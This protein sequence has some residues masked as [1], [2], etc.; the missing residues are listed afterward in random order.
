VEEQ[1]G[2]TVTSLKEG[3][4]GVVL[5]I[6]GRQSL[7]SRLA[8]MGIM[9]GTVIK[10]LR[11]GTGPVILLASDTRLALGRLEA[12]RVFVSKI[13]PSAEK[14]ELLVALAGQPNVGKSTVFNI[15][16]G[17]SQAVGNWPGKTV[18]KKEGVHLASN[19]ELHIVDLPG[20]YGLTAFSE[21]ERAAREF[22]IHERPD[23]IVAVVNAAALERSLYLLSELLLLDIPIVVAVNMMD[24]AESQGIR[25]DVDALQ[26]SLGLPVVSII[27]TKNKGIK[28]L[29]PLIVDAGRHK[30]DHKPRLP[31][32]SHEHMDIYTR[33][34]GLVKDHVPHPYTN[35][36]MATKLMEGDPEVASTLQGLLPER[37]WN[38]TQALLVEHEDALRAVVGGR[39]DWIEMVT[40]VAVSRFKRGQVLM[41]DR[42]DHL[43]T[44]PIL[45]IP[46]LLGI[47]AVVFV[48][49]YKVGFPV[50][51]LL[52][53]MMAIFAGA[54]ETSLG[55]APQWL[56]A[57]AVNGVIGG[58][59]SVLTFLPILLIFFTCLTFLED[60]GYMARAAFV[61]DRFMH[62]VGLHGKSFLPL[63]LGFGCNVPSIM[64][65]RI[66]ESKKA[67]LLTVFLAPFVPCTA[68]LAVLAFV[69]AAV[70]GTHPSLVSWALL[71][72]NIVVLGL[73]GMV[74]GRVL[75]KG[76]P[77]PFIMELPLYHKPDPRTI[78]LV[79]W[80]RT[81]AFV[82]R[83]GTVILGASVAIWLLSNIPGGQV[84]TSLLGSLGKLIEPV[85]RPMGLGWKEI[86]AL[87][88]SLVA[89][90][91]SVATL[92]VLYG[93]GQEGLRQVLPQVMSHASAL[94]F[95]V[96]LMLFVPCA[97]TVAAM[98][99]EMGSG[100][101]FVASFLF[102]VL[103]SFLSGTL[104]YHAALA[105]GI[106]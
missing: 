96:V 44:Q 46:I 55:G 13:I 80:N 27:A 20:T 8:G 49:T 9:S 51:H 19:V 28:E 72:V 68:R 11:N 84:E 52:E 70:F 74:I 18:E 99:Q 24:V 85:G 92:A 64:G 65:A 25:V 56:K 104:A 43:L 78:A 50:Q 63:C 12:S 79:V 89:K 88:S 33:L 10:M 22:V 58:A 34:L 53:R 45:G 77:M 93:V 31:E 66:I 16:T 48:L 60:V 57:L 1:K 76:E 67:R 97:A 42:I 105:L 98:K 95:L 7:T 37:A 2:I 61:M 4:E 26:R 23:V 40:R 15:L 47:L 32:V 5:S 100:K 54:V 35:R 41:T 102:M 106:G 17:L 69:C 86:V 62:V 6:A 82:K 73:A 30:V 39:Y 29:V 94:A 90:E 81:I 21:E 103:I 101:W 87:L 59:G 75:M 14:T 38:E 71:S 36:W 91:N 83:A 3:E